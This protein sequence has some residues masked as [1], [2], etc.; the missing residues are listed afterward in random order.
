EPGEGRS[1]DR[2]LSPSQQ[3]PVPP[4]GPVARVTGHCRHHSSH[5]SHHPAGR[6]PMRGAYSHPVTQPKDDSAIERA[7]VV[8]AH[9]DD[10]D[11]GCSG[12]IAGWTAAGIE[13]TLLVLTRGEQGGLADADSHGMP[14]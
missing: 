12:T 2:S 7:L 13:V 11:F 6:V 4:P 10:A 1:R 5:R 14:A 9:P 3:P 8:A